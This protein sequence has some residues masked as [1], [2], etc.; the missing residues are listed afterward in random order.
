MYRLII[1]ALDYRS[2]Q[3]ITFAWNLIKLYVYRL[4][5]YVCM[6]L[7][8][9]QNLYVMFSSISWFPGIIFFLILSDLQQLQYHHAHNLCKVLGNR[10]RP[11]LRM[12]FKLGP[13]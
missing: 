5:F 7:Y 1:R 10:H 11:T 2:V 6:I 4:F 13:I 8:Y 3:R 12:S 9:L